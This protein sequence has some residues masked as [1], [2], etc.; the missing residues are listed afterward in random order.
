MKKFTVLGI[1]GGAAILTAVPLSPHWSQ[2]G[3]S[4]VGKAVGLLCNT[5][6]RRLANYV[7]IAF[8]LCRHL[9]STGV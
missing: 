2:Q 6:R 4:L 9:R 5:K 7:S 3:V 8:C 1:I